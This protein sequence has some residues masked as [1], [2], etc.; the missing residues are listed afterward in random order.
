MA[1]RKQSATARKKVPK[2]K[3]AGAEV[4]AYLAALS[5]DARRHLKKLREAIR[6]AAPGAVEA[7]GYGIPAFRLE[8]RPLVYY[9]A[10]KQHSSL[11]PIGPAIRR[12]HASDLE[13]Y[14]T[15]KGTVR[16]PLTKP[17]PTALVRRLVKARI[18]ELRMK[19]KP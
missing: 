14:E 19:G 5:P 13:G 3:P 6:A 2:A 15:S 11:Y 17:V 7:F 1:P 16:F 8:G 10:W 18:A 4:Q 12:V 9:A